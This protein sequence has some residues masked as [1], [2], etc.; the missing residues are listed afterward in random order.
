MISNLA[1]AI[2]LARSRS[3]GWGKFMKKLMWYLRYF[4]REWHEVHDEG[5]SLG[6]RIVLTILHPFNHSILAHWK[7]WLLFGFHVGNHNPYLSFD[8]NEPINPN[9]FLTKISLPHQDQIQY[10]LLFDLVFF[11]ELF[12][13]LPKA[14]HTSILFEELIFFYQYLVIIWVLLPLIQISHRVKLIL[15][16]LW[17]DPKED[18]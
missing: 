11:R 4:T 3:C 17:Y 15:Y 2:S 10:L 9:Y 7:Q 13:D 18:T 6:F 16:F 12:L 1:E 8:V 5:N 14:Y